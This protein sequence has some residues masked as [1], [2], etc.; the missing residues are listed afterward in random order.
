MGYGETYGSL[1]EAIAEEADAVVMRYF[2]ADELR[3]ERKGD[4]TAVTQATGAGKEWGG[5]KGRGSGLVLEEFGGGWAGG[6]EKLGGIW[7]GGGM[8]MIRMK[9]TREFSRG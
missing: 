2:R 1:L 4:G 9:G 5:E 6:E 7:G 3:I 8:I